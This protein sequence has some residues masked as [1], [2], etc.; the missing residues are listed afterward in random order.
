MIKIKKSKVFISKIDKDF[1]PT[2]VPYHPSQNYP[3]YRFN[4]FS[5]QNNHIYEGFRNLLFLMGLDKENWNTKNWNPFKNFIFPKQ[6][7]LI[8]PN[9]VMHRNILT[10]I[11]HPSL[12]RVI[13]DYVLIALNGEGEIIIGD[14][15]LQECNFVK[16]IEKS[17]YIDVCNFYLSRSINL[18]LIDFRTERL[19]YKRDIA[20][21]TDRYIKTIRLK[22]DPKG[23]TVINLGEKSFFKNNNKLGDYKRF[24]VT[25]YNPFLMKKAHNNQD[26]KYLISN[27]LLDSDV[28][29]FAPKIKTH[30]KAGITGCLKI[31]VGINGHKDWLPHHRKGP[32][33]DGGDEYFKRNILHKIYS[34]IC[35]IDYFLLTNHPVLRNLN[36]YLII[37]LK[38]FFSKFTKLLDRNT[39]FEGSWYGND[40][41]W[42]TI[43]DLNIIL[44]YCDKKGVLKTADQRNRIYFVDGVI[45]GEGEGPLDAQPKKLGAI[46]GGFDP[47][48]IDQALSRLM[49]FDYKKIP[50]INQLFKIKDYKITNHL[51][52]E[53]LIRSNKREWDKKNINNL[54]EFIRFKPTNGWKGHI[55][56]EKS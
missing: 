39:Y 38:G 33:D 44:K 15:P 32:I 24:R 22:G 3:E 31:A 49:G 21:K 48:L 50:Q 43:A 42:R 11:T 54:S 46:I 51:P 47:L 40:T 36:Y 35:D 28:V 34:E 9:M 17:G 4:A 52:D 20:T 16:L 45:A 6:K 27:S 13:I 18:R 19:L 30:R 23:Y 29:I 1:Y 41:I 12:I 26:H 2:E 8:K 10:S 53:L 25:D 7:V 37:G 56:I 55:E 14:A 5:S